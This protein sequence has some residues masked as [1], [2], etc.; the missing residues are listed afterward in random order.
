[1][2][3]IVK[4][5]YLKKYCPQ[6]ESVPSCP[7]DPLRDI[8][9]KEVG[10]YTFYCYS[11]VNRSFTFGFLSALWQLQ[12][13]WHVRKDILTR[14]IPTFTKQ[15]K[16][17]EWKCGLTCGRWIKKKH[18]YIKII[19]CVFFDS[20]KGVLALIL[21]YYECEK[22]PLKSYVTSEGAV[23]GCFILSTALHWSLPNKFKINVQ[24]IFWVITNG[25]HHCL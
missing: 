16:K 23:S 8:K 5:T 11:T 6:R 21:W 12:C 10:R 17:S 25:F 2:R 3:P 15:N 1:M 22:L 20:L 14:H 9:T 13:K 24:H 19:Q 4:S 7:R 18:F